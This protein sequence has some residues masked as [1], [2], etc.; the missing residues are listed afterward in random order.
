MANF[1]YMGTKRAL[2]DNIAEVCLGCEHGT[3]LELFSGLSAV[4]Q[5]I[6]QRRNLWFND[7]QKF[8]NLYCEVMY[9]QSGDY[10][11]TAEALSEFHKAY[12]R[13]LNNIKS[14]VGKLTLEEE[15]CLK[16]DSAVA[17]REWQESAYINVSEMDIRRSNFG[18]HGLFTT[19][20]SFG[21]IGLQQAI[22]VDC[23]RSA[24]DDLS[25]DNIISKEQFNFGLLALCLAVSNVSNSTGHFAQFLTPN[26]K[27]IRR[28]LSKRMLS[29]IDLF[30]RSLG[31]IS[32]V[33]DDRWRRDNRIFNSDAVGLLD[34]LGDSK[35]RPK[36]VYAD[37]PYTSDQYSR[38]YHL[39]ETIV[40]YDYPEITGKG[41]YRVGRASSSFS[42]SSQV[43]TAFEMLIEKTA[44]LEA[45]LVLSYPKTGLL[46]GSSE[47]IPEIMRKYFGKV[48]D[49]VEIDHVHSTLGAS[50]GPNRQ[51]VT[52][53]LFVAQMT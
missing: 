29:V 10:L 51:S 28:V 21:Y 41:R 15:V 26:E 32:P 34:T 20:Y 53:I 2:A 27:N 48:D 19:K 24:L 49:P 25:Q 52:E 5:A 44:L 30:K 23:I 4:G 12:Y 17:L 47:V 46:E 22:E 31:V 43:K 18:T 7:L 42:L 3:V 16:K 8:S 50:K 37:P 36:V 35:I 9:R 33:G 39:L 14:V 40:L 45:S 13:H 38:F 1:T 6:G 11:M